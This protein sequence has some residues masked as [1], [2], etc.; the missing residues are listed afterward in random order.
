MIGEIMKKMKPSKRKNKRNEDWSVLDEIRHPVPKPGF[1][2]KDRKRALK[3]EETRK[4][5]RNFNAD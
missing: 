4:E 3:E 2:F 5:I 1:A